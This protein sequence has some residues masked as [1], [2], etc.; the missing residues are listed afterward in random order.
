MLSHVVSPPP[1]TPFSPFRTWVRSKKHLS[2]KIWKLFS[3]SNW[4]DTWPIPGT[5]ENYYLFNNYNSDSGGTVADWLARPHY[6]AEIRDSIP[7]SGLLVWS[8]YLLPVPV[9]LGWLPLQWHKP[10][11][12]KLKTTWSPSASSYIGGQPYRQINCGADFIQ[13]S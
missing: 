8:L 10:I 9:F 7:G 5:W 4:E 1:P 3:K 2:V 12:N 11:K 6:T 13:P